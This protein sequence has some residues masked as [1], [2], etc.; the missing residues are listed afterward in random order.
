MTY[1][2]NDRQIC[3]LKSTLNLKECN[4]V[5]AFLIIIIH[6]CT[7]F[8]SRYMRTHDFFILT[9]CDTDALR[10]LLNFRGSDAAI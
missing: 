1:S 2:V 5:H 3:F 6:D 7:M 10:R 9:G 4:P 8:D